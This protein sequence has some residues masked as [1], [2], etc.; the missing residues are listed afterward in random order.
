MALSSVKWYT[1]QIYTK[2]DVHSR[3]Q[4]VIRARELA[5]GGP[6]APAVSADQVHAGRE[7]QTPLLPRSPSSFIGREHERATI[8]QALET[9]SARLITLTGPAG[10]G[11]TRLAGELAADLVP[12]F[13]ARV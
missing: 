11:K 4:A 10:C 2:L 7:D 1:R 8:K 9:T 5:L 3:E 13:Q 6:E 12:A